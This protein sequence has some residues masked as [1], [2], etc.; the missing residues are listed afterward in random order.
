M[1][2]MVYIY[3]I[4]FQIKYLIKYL[5]FAHLVYK[6]ANYGKNVRNINSYWIQRERFLSFGIINN[7]LIKIHSPYL[8]FTFAHRVSK[9]E[10]FSKM[11]DV[12]HREFQRGL[13]DA[14]VI[15]NMLLTKKNLL[16]YMYQIHINWKK[17]HNRIQPVVFP[18]KIT[19][20]FSSTFSK[21]SLC[22]E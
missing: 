14:D 2:K 1:M 9:F 20:I 12:R 6:I 4:S 11:H 10:F 15:V 17:K 13:L 8:I 7:W 16:A 5:V 21:V 3:L 18:V 22:I 19:Y